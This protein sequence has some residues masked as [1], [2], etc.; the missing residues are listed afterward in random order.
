M[1]FEIGTCSSKPDPLS[2]L[3]YLLQNLYKFGLSDTVCPEMLISLC[4][5]IWPQ[6]YLD[7][8]MHWPPEGSL[9][10]TVLQELKNFCRH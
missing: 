3:G 8:G 9:E 1:D 2:L 7:N 6:Y 5:K 10:L 4:T